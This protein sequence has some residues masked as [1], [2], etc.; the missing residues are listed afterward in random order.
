M[1]NQYEPL[2][3]YRR[4]F[5]VVHSFRGYSLPILFERASLSWE[6]SHYVYKG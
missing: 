2:A 1:T 6:Y 4:A 5:S 3:S